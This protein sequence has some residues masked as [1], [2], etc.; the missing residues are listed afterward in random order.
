[1]TVVTLHRLIDGPICLGAA[2]LERYQKI[3]K[4]GALLVSTGSYGDLSD[5]ILVLRS[6]GYSHFEVS[7]LV[8]PAQQ[9]A[10]E[11]LVAKGMSEP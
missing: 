4:M 7:A 1:M 10:L 9:E 5:S 6:A 11:Q 8:A 3:V 2:R